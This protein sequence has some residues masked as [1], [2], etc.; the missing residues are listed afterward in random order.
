MR[1]VPVFL[2]YCHDN[3]SDRKVLGELLTS[4]G[5]KLGVD[6]LAY[7]DNRSGPW[8]PQIQAYIE[9]ARIAVFLITPGFIKSSYCSWEWREALEEKGRLRLVPVLVEDCKWSSSKFPWLDD[10]HFAFLKAPV[11]KEAE[12]DK[13]W[14]EVADFILGEALIVLR[15]GSKTELKKESRAA[16]WEALSNGLFT[17]VLGSECHPLREELEEA[18]PFLEQRLRWLLSH[19]LNSQEEAYL[20]SVILANARGMEL[21]R[22]PRVPRRDESAWRRELI[23]FQAAVTRAGAEA[24]RLFMKALDAGDQ[25]LADLDGVKVD[26]V[27]R[28]RRDEDPQDL[29]ALLVESA[30]LAAELEAKWNSRTES[31]GLGLKGIR[32]GLVWLT[33]AIFYEEFQNDQDLDE[34]AEKWREDHPFANL[35]LMPRIGPP[36]LGLWYLQWLADLLWH[37]LRFDLP[38]YPSAKDLAFHF[39][40]CCRRVMLPQRISLERAALV[41][42]DEER[43]E[44]VR[45]ALRGYASRQAASASSQRLFRG[46]TRASLFKMR[47]PEREW[48]ADSSMPSWRVWRHASTASKP[49]VIMNANFDMEI[50]HEL[51][52]V[53][54]S[55][56]ILMPV[57]V[58]CSR[59]RGEVYSHDDW[60]LALREAGSGKLEWILWGDDLEE[61]IVRL[62]RDRL[63]GPLVMKVCGSPLQV[64]PDRPEVVLTKTATYVR[65]AAIQEIRHRLILSEIDLVMHTVPKGWRFLL[66]DS[67]RVLCFIGHSTADIASQLQWHDFGKEDWGQPGL[68]VV[69]AA[70]DQAR[71]A[72]YEHAKVRLLHLDIDSLPKIIDELLNQ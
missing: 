46:L 72:L 18:R 42:N 26:L 24:S 29:R 2:S 19:N 35:Q 15:R 40:L 1:R 39:S 20:R 23:K 45:S 4:M 67:A 65:D 32:R 51:V 21:S 48:N 68:L 9:R 49:H 54:E 22:P 41:S 14:R 31:L 10:L 17:P 55:F 16:L 25:S 30:T 34:I 58:I 52:N 71:L 7:D 36:Q 63:S 66:A 61:S 69:E 12:P 13:A 59:Q 62:V 3:S 28:E 27:R 57:R 60:L 5:E 37:T 47:E 44:L 53:E 43:T 56:A 50:E 11:R 8:Q 6:V 64:L 38:L 33:W 70:E